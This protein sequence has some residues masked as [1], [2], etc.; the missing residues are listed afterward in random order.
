MN[1]GPEGVF[2]ADFPHLKRTRCETNEHDDVVR[3]LESWKG[4]YVRG[5]WAD[6]SRNSW[7]MRN[8]L[9]R[10][11]EIELEDVGISPPDIIVGTVE[12]DYYQTN[13]HFYG[14]TVDFLYHVE[15]P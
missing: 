4:M 8:I 13:N 14:L 5:I 2:F 11:L 10:E 6:P 9:A 3:G 7:D 12:A 15:A 1:E